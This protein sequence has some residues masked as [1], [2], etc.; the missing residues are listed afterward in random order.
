MGYTPQYK[1]TSLPVR[2][3][4]WRVTPHRFHPDRVRVQIRRAV[5]TDFF[6]GSWRLVSESTN[7]SEQHVENAA[8]RLYENAK[9]NAR[10]AR[11]ADPHLYGDFYV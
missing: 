2:K 4:F 7:N 9:N 1:L 5:K 6:S 10:F 8:K 11:L 3:Y